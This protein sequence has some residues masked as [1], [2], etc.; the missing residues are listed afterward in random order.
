MCRAISGIAVMKN[1]SHVEVFTLKHSDSHQ[2]I[3]E[4]YKLRDHNNPLSAYQTPVELI[5]VDDLF[6]VKGMTFIFDGGRPSWWTDSHTQDAISQLHQ[7]WLS[8]WIDKRALPFPEDLDLSSLKALPQGIGISA[9][10]SL[11]LSSLTELPSGTKLKA[12]K[13]LNLR[14]VEKSG[15]KIMLSADTLILSR[16]SSIPQRSIIM[17]GAIGL[18]FTQS[19]HQDSIICASWSIELPSLKRVKDRVTIASGD[20]I[21]LRDPKEISKTSLIQAPTIYLSKGVYKGFPKIQ[22][23]I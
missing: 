17:G 20:H 22:D 21:K 12:R 8:R 5:P 23:L 19:I 14:I 4:Y 18:N 16:L 3:R 11:I 1:E 9:Q 13:T 15:T 7:A 6:D 10:G 2:R